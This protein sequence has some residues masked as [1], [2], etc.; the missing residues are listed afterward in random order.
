MNPNLAELRKK[1][2]ALPLRPGVYLMKNKAGTII[3][4]GK[5]KSLKNRVSQYFGSPK[6]H[7][8]KV[9][10]MVGGYGGGRQVA[11]VVTKPKTAK[12]S[13]QQREALESAVHGA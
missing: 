1:A 11:F 6:N 9:R 3:Y 12:E 7:D 2:M 4:I 13:E 8:A 5:A 10:Q